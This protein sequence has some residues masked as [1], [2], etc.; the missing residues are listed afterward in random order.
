MRGEELYEQFMK[1]NKP[2]PI[3]KNKKRNDNDEVVITIPLKG[4]QGAPAKLDDNFVKV[5]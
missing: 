3:Q 4:G 5:I 1:K 2:P